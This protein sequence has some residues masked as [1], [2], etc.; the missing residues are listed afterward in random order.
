MY[1]S[2]GPLPWRRAD[3]EHGKRAQRLGI[4]GSKTIHQ[5]KLRIRQDFAALEPVLYEG[6]G[7]EGA[8]QTARHE[9]AASGGI[10]VKRPLLQSAETLESAFVKVF[11]TGRAGKEQY[12]PF[13]TGAKCQQH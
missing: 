12:G 4:S 7:L 5:A 6:G 1:G 2:Q 8:H 9:T 11:N 3:A 13:E 10:K